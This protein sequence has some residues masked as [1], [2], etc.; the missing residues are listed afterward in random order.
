MF[1]AAVVLLGAW[2]AWLGLRPHVPIAGTPPQG[3]GQPAA[4]APL[5]QGVTDSTIT[6]GCTTSYSG[7]NQ[8]VGQNFVAGIR[9]AFDSI[10]DQ[11]GING[12]KLKLIVL[13]DGY[14]PDR[15]LANMRDLYERRKVFGVQH[16]LAIEGSAG[17][18][19]ERL[20]LGH[21]SIPVR[22]GGAKSASFEVAKG[23]LVGSYHAGSSAG[24]DAHIA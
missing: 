14:E 7:T 22:A 3:D 13:D 9:T 11:G 16:Q 12:R 5:A 10:N 20:P 23:G 19:G 17:I 18:G 2:G 15:A 4:T 6:F 8:Q 24:L 21:S 1:A